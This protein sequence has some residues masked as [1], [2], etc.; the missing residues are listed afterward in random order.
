[1]IPANV[2]VT[3]TL[4]IDNRTGFVVAA[5]PEKGLPAGTVG[6]VGPKPTPKSSRASPALAATVLYPRDVP[7]G[8]SF[9][10]DPCFDF[11]DNAADR[12]R[13]GPTATGRETK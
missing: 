6:L 5:A 2:G 13:H 1:V 12:R 9:A 7:V 10:A 8:P 11:G 3:V 4:L